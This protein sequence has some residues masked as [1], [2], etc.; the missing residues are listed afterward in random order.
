[1]N[2]G[3]TILSSGPKG[4]FTFSFDVKTYVGKDFW[5][6]EFKIPHARINAEPPQKGT[7]WG[8]N[9]RRNRTQ[10]ASTVSEWSRMRGFPAQPQ[11]FGI[12]RFE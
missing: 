11:Y 12:L 4:L 3:G 6:A 9:V 8:M 5:S 2:P 10:A 1:V 7:E